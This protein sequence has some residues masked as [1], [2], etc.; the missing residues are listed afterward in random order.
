VS[1]PSV[2]TPIKL[3]RERT[4]VCGMNAFATAEEVLGFGLMN[5]VRFEEIRVVRALVWASLL[6]EDPS[7]KLHE[8]GEM[9]DNAPGGWGYVSDRIQLAMMNAQPRAAESGDEPDETKEGS[10]EDPFPLKTGS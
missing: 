2:K 4:L 3:D 6:H 5:E 1:I 7:L 10:E 9:C 8:V